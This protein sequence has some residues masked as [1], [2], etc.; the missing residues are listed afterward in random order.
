MANKIPRVPVREQDPKVRATNFEEVCYGYDADEARLEASRCLTCP[1]P[2]CVTRCPVHIDIPSFIK[3]VADGDFRQ[4]ARV[5]SRDSS[6]PSVCG[7]VCPQESQ[8][9]GACV[10]GIKGEPVAIGKLERFTG[11][12]AIQNE[13]ERQESSRRRFRSF[14]PRLRLRPC[15]PRLQSQDIR[16]SAQSGRRT[17]IRHTRIPPPQRPHRSQGG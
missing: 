11:D 15:P 9:E 2:H 12:W 8:C 13:E 5:I 1:K 6:L 7:R 17:R 3:N 10:L 4:A 14:R 16:G